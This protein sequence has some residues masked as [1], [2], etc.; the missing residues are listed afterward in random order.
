MR[1]I[2]TTI[3]ISYI[4]IPNKELVETLLY[5]NDFNIFQAIIFIDTI[6]FYFCFIPI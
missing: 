5:F 6:S 2:D 1:V 3:Y 4:R